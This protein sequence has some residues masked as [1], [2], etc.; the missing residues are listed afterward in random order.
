MRAVTGAF[1]LFGTAFTLALL[2]GTSACSIETKASDVICVKDQ[3]DI[4]TNCERPEGDTRSYRGQ[5]T[6]AADGKSFGACMQCAPVGDEDDEEDKPKDPGDFKPVPA[7]NTAGPTTPMDQSCNKKMTLVAG[8]DDPADQFVYAAV[9]LNGKFNVFSSSGAPMRSQGTFI[10]NEGALMGV[11]R[12]KGSSLV[13]ST[14][15]DGLWNAPAAVPGATTD[16]TPSI[17]SWG[18]KAKVIFHSADNRYN[19]IDW[20]PVAGVWS[21]PVQ[22]GAA[23]AGASGTS[24]PAAATVGAPGVPGGGIM[25][26]YT[27]NEGGLYRQDWN[28]TSWRGASVKSTLVNALPMKTSLISMNGGAFDLV[29]AFTASGGFPYISTRSVKDNMSQWS[30]PILVT[31]EA[32]PLDGLNGVPLSNGRALF[33]YRNAQKKGF[34]VMFDPA[35]DPKFTRP[36]PLF[37]T[38]TN[39]VLASTPVVVE[40]RCGADAVLAYAESDG[41]VGVLRF[42]GDTWKGPFVVP[43]ISKMTYAMTAVLP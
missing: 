29:S 23:A 8:K 43:G 34:Y 26:G 4:C 14:F 16:M 11:Y 7:D 22:V 25:F 42:T 32:S 17:V 24:P 19:A 37:G 6:C 5:H 30:N 27:D 12:S 1:V 13:S 36:A 18:K 39:P 35:K 33:V 31:D 41:A 38:G 21:A 3:T 15:K 20:D 40:D 28:G 9:V 2:T 10:I